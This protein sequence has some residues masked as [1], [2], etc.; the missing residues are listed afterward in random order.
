MLA[1]AGAGAAVFGRALSALAAGGPKV[2]AEMVKQAEWISGV[3]FTDEER[4]LMLEDLNETAEGIAAL[5]EVDLDNAVPPAFTFAPSPGAPKPGPDA[6][7]PAAPAGTPRRD[8][9]LRTTSSPS[10]RSATSA[11]SCGRR[12]SPRRS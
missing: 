9:P 5:R 11:G 1:G 3:A 10:R 7:A 8:A 6:A 4:A 12:R 2:T